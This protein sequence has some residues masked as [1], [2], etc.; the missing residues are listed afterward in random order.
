MSDETFEWP[1]S[2]E[3]EPELA[4]RLYE[5]HCAILV[6]EYL[7]PASEFGIDLMNHR[8]G[9]NF[10]GVKLI[11]PGLHI[12][13][14]SAVDKSTNQIGPKSGFFH[15]FKSGELVVKRWSEQQED[16]DDTHQPSEDDLLVYMTNLKDLDRYLGAYSFS[17]YQSYSTMTHKLTPATVERLMPKSNRLR[18]VPYLTRTE[19]QTKLSTSSFDETPNRP[20][21]RFTDK[22]DEKNLMPHLIPDQNNAINFTN[23]PDTHLESQKPI[24]SDEITQFNLDTSQKMDSCFQNR[25]N[26]LAEFQFA[27]VT[28]LVCHVYQCFEHWKALL[29]MICLADA[30]IKNDTQ[31]YAEFLRIVRHQIDQIP[32]DLFE[33]ITDSK[34]LVRD[35]LDILFQNIGDTSLDELKQQAWDFRIHLET[36]FGWQFNLENE[37]EQPVIV[38]L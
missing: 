4:R 24:A 5:K 37:D 20:I 25:D 8:I 23:I 1:R 2:D 13:Y 9:E 19:D 36:K 6:V 3:I 31:F 30:A 17:L 27:F 18:Q 38:E 14:A 28:F 32:N 16:F 21:R 12:V 26:L 33:D 34:N 35:R 29:S 11:P 7:P 10:K 22:A 15:N